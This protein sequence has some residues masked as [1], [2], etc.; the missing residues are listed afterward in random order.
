MSEPAILAADIKSVENA[1]KAAV[2]DIKALV[3]NRVGDLMIALIVFG[4]IWFGHAL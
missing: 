4:S 3:A 2:T 1:T